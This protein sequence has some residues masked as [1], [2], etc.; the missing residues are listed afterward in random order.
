MSTII[1]WQSRPTT[2]HDYRAEIENQEMQI[3]IFI[4]RT[5]EYIEL[6]PVRFTITVHDSTRTFRSKN[7]V[8]VK[9]Q[10]INYRAS[11]W[12]QVYLH[13][14]GVA[15]E[16]KGERER[17]DDE[18][19]GEESAAI[20][21]AV[22]VEEEDEKEKKEKKKKKKRQKKKD[23]TDLVFETMATLSSPVL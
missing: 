10:M 3:R 17:E 19:R 11:L 8:N 6:R 1:S 16:K 20:A 5:H 13:A 23:R 9:K 2:E 7:Q 18:K 4:T 15:Q 14:P 12:I 22:V 21:T